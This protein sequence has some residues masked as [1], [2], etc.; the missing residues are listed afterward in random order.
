VTPYYQDD[1]VTLYHGDCR[2]VLP[3]LDAAATV[4]VTDPPYGETN[5]SWD[6][7]PKGWVA[8]VPSSSMWCFGSTRL[9]LER[10]EEFTTAGWRMSQDV[11]WEKDESSGFET[12]RFRRVHEMALHWYRGQWSAVY[13]AT[14]REPTYGPRKGVIRRNPTPSK[15]KGARGPAIYID[16]GYRIRRSVLYATR[17]RYVEGQHP[18]EKPLSILAPLIE[19]AVPVDGVLLDPFAGS[20][21]T[22]VAAKHSGRRSVG[23]EADERWAELAAQRCSQEVL[24]LVV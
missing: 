8:T 13:H 4:V 19:Y 12:D 5:H 11:V 3:V 18:T 10:A 7:W 14:P 17:I 24:G 1:L 20:G 2:D 16:D 21:S 6:V 15:T 23:I 22:L 9:F